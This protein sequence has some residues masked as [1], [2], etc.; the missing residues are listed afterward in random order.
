MSIKH[1][2]VPATSCPSCG[3]TLD[4]ATGA[5]GRHRPK[6]GDFT[7]CFYCGHVLVFGEGLKLHEPNDREMHA[8][9]GNKLLLRMQQVR[10]EALK[11]FEKKT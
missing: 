9:A 3:K 10:V 6:E 2:E 1:T 7:V 5:T 4:M 8:V 11:R